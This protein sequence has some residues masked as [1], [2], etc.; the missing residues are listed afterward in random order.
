MKKTPGDHLS[1]AANLSKDWGPPL[2]YVGYNTDGTYRTRWLGIASPFTGQL[3]DVHD[4]GPSADFDSL[5]TDPLSQVYNADSETFYDPYPPVYFDIRPMSIE[6]RTIGFNCQY[7]ESSNDT[8]CG[9]GF[10]S[11][12]RMFCADGYAPFRF[13][14]VDTDTCD[15]IAEYAI[16]GGSIGSLATAG[17]PRSLFT[18]DVAKSDTDAIISWDTAST[19]QDYDVVMGSLSVLRDSN[20]DFETGTEMC[21]ADDFTGTEVTVW[22]LPDSGDGF[23]FLVRPQDCGTYDCSLPSQVAGR[24]SG[25]VASGFGC[26]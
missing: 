13:L 14:E 10:V 21:V 17:L 20:G 12:D 19:A 9:L 7:Q 6:P 25:I 3:T 26:E 23:Y 18:L 8:S 16:E 1:Y 22:E 15:L 5:A 24:D 2:L 4:Y 11:S